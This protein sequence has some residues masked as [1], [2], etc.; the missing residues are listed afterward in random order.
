[1]RV[2]RTG[3]DIL[4]RFTPTPFTADLRLMGCAIR[5]ESNSETVIK[6]A[7]RALGDSHAGPAGQFLWRVISEQDAN[8]APRWP[9]PYVFSGDHLRLAS[10][11]RCGFIAVDLAARLAVGFLPEVLARDDLGFR[12]L[13]L[14]PL[15][16]MTAEALGLKSRNPEEVKV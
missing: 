3:P 6:Q 4:R 16:S 7:R 11:G 10:I 13:Y 1:M 9:E 14:A 8:H 12:N 5:L 15:V 2:G